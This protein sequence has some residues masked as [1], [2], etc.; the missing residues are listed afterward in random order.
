MN[1]LVNLVA[2]KTG[3]PADKAQM[4]VQTVMGYLKDKLPAPIAGQLDNFM[5]GST[6]STVAGNT[7]GSTTA[8][9]TGNTAGSSA[10]N[11][12]GDVMKDVGSMFGNK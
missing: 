3:I 9:T 8:N 1:E 2:Q 11:A 4:A 7:T 6:A 12:V 10:S 5:G